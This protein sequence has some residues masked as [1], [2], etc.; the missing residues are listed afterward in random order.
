[1]PSETSS[2]EKLRVIVAGGGV[3]ALETILALREL[4]PDLTDVSVAPALV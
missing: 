1:M 3:A 2:T 4:A